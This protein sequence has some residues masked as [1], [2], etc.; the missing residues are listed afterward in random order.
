M[1]ANRQSVVIVVVSCATSTTQSTAPNAI[2][3][4]MG[5]SSDGPFYLKH[6]AF[7]SSAVVVQLLPSESTSFFG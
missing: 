5:Y 1:A 3:I 4:S 2:F 6:N 7:G